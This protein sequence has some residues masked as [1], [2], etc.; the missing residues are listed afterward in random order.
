[1]SRALSL[2]AHAVAIAVLVVFLLGVS[3]GIA[4]EA[5]SRRGSLDA[6]LYCG[7]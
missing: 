7:R 6:L 5:G 2:R 4:Y 3:H 1:M